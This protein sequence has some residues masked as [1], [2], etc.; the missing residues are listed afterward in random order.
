MADFK[1]YP[2]TNKK[3]Q[4]VSFLY[5]IE[6]E[7]VIKKNKW[8][9]SITAQG[10]IYIKNGKRKLLHRLLLKAQKGEIVDHINGDTLDNRKENL[11]I[12]DSSGNNKNRKGYSKTGLKFFTLFNRPKHSKAYCIYVPN[13][14]KKQFT[15]KKNAEAYYLKCLMS[16]EGGLKW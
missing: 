13:F 15:D 9:F 8:H 3:G 16:L 14:P 4:S 5:D 11:R 6:D 10:K 7:D 2:I 12:T 1:A